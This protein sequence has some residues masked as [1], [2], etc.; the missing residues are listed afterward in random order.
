L[1]GL[2]TGIGS[3]FLAGVYANPKDREEF[4]RRVKGYLSKVQHGMLGNIVKSIV[5][6]DDMN[7]VHFTVGNLT[8][9]P[10]AGVQ[11]TVTVPHSNLL[12]YT[13]APSVDQ[14]PPLPKWPDEIR[15]RMAPMTAPALAQ[16]YDFDPHGGTVSEM[17]EGFEVT[18]DVGD[19]RP[20]EWS[21]LLEITVVPGLGA[22]DEVEITMAA[23]AM[24]RR[25]RVTDTA[26]LTISSDEWTP[27]DFYVAE[28]D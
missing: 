18:W 17:S 6:S 3:T 11:F 14:L 1:S 20:G 24:N 10:V 21:R 15:D 13:S 9:D 7:K 22:P 25:R 28:N 23:G 12:V 2:S 26:T 5:R 27:D 16:D 19:L 8:D 4:D